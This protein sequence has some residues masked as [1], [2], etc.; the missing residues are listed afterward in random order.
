MYLA[1]VLKLALE[2]T[3]GAKSQNVDL[4]KLIKSL[5]NNA[6]DIEDIFALEELDKKI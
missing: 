2:A 1:K 3:Y 4:E 5:R 6:K